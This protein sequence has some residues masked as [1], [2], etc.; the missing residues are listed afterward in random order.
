VALKSDLSCLEI[1][2]NTRI[3]GFVF[4]CVTCSALIVFCIDLVVA[5]NNFVEFNFVR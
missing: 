5:Q 1:L 4:I 2:E 3:W